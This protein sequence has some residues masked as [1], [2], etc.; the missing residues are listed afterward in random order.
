MR[1]LTRFLACFL[2]A[3]LVVSNVQY[4]GVVKAAE[5]EEVT[6]EAISEES[7]ADVTLE[8]SE[9]AATEKIF[10]FNDL[11]TP[12]GYGYEI[13]V[14]EETGA[15]TIKY[16]ND[17]GYGE[18]RYNLPADFDTSKV[19]KVEVLVEEQVSAIGLK[20]FLLADAGGYV[21]DEWGGAADAMV[22][23]GAP[24]VE[25]EWQFKSLGIF[26]PEVTNEVKLTGIKIT[27]GDATK[28][29]K[30]P[31]AEEPDEFEGVKGTHDESWFAFKTYT[32]EAYAD[33]WSTQT[34][35]VYRNKTITPAADT[36][37][38]LTHVAIMSLYPDDLTETPTY[39]A[40]FTDVTFVSGSEEEVTNVYT[41]ND[42]TIDYD[43]TAIE[44][45]VLANG[46]AN[47]TFTGNYKSVFVAIPEE[48][49]GKE[50]KSITFNTIIA[51]KSD[52]TYGDNIIINPNFAE[53]DLSAWS[54]GVQ[55]ATIKKETAEAP[56]FGDVN[57]YAVIDRDATWVSE[58]GT[59]D[60]RHEFFAQDITAAIEAGGDLNRKPSYKVEF[61][62]KLSDDYKDAP[63]AQRV[64]E[65]A[66][67]IV[68]EQDGAVYLG[69]SYSTQLSG[70][71]S[72]TLTVGEW[73][74]YSGTFDVTHDGTIKQVVIRIIEQGTEYGDLAKGECVKGD[75]YVTGVSLTEVFKP[76][77]TIET[78]IPNWKDAITDAF[79]DDAIAGTCL[80][81]GTI[82]F[83]YLQEL[84]KKHFNA[85]TF[86]NEMK[87]D[88][89]LG[90]TPTLD[91]NG[92]LVYN[93]AVAD[94][95]L[96]QIKG[97]ND[98]DKNDD[99]NFKIRGHVLVWHSQT[100]E[101]FFHEDYD[102]N[103]D[104]VT[105][106]VMNTRLEHY[107]KGVLTHYNEYKFED[108]TSAADMFYGWDIVNEAMSDSTGKPRKASDN[109]NWARVY[110]DE[111]NEY[112]IN[113][114][115]YANKYAPEHIR[116]Y[117][118]DYNDSNEPKASGIAAL[119]AEITSH[120][121]D[122]EN[123]TRIDGVGMQAHHNFGDPTA[124]QIK[125][126]I[127]KYL[128]A[129][130]EGGVVEM[131]EFDVKRSS[132]YDGSAASLASEHAKQAWRFKEIFDVYRATEA[133]KPGSVGGITMWGLVDERSWLQSQGT[134]GGGSTGGAHAPLLFY[135]D[136]YVAKA[137]PAFY[138]F[139]DEYVAEL[140]PFIQSVTVMQQTAEGDFGKGISYDLAGVGT[141]VPMWTADGLTFKVDVVDATDDKEKDTITVYLD[142]AGSKSE[143]DYKKV[144][145]DRTAEGVTSTEAGYSTIINIP[146][147]N[148]VSGKTFSFDIAVADNDKVSVFN[149]KKGSQA[150]T[151]K[152]YAEAIIKPYASIQYGSVVI[153]AEED[154]SWSKVDAIPLTIVLGA[155]AS[156]TVKALWDNEYLYVYGEVKDAELDNTSTQAHEVD[157]L[158]VFIDENNAKA[159]S[160][161]DD[162]KQYRISY[163][164]VQSF[165]GPKCTADNVISAARITEDGYVVEAAFK[166]TDIT[167]AAGQEIGIEFQINDA[168]GGTRT[169]T[170]SWFD[171]SG[172]GWS[173][174]A[175]FGVAALEANFDMS[176]D[177][178]EDQVY[179]GSAIKP[180]IAVYNG[181][182]KLEEG[183]DYTVK[184]SNNVKVGEAIVT[185]TGKGNFTKKETV[186]FNI[187]AK[188]IAAEDVD[189]ADITVVYNKKEQKPVPVINYN[190]KKL[191]NK[192]DFTVEYPTEGE[193]AYKEAGE[194]VIKVT[195][196]GNFTGT[197]EIKLAITNDTLMSKAKIS[198]IAAQAYTGAA[199]T[200]DV[201]VKVGKDTL[202]KDKHYT[203]EYSDNIAVGT[204]T[205]TVKAIAGSG[206]VGEKTATF[207]INGTALKTAKIAGIEKAYDYTGS[208]I[209][210][211]AK[212]TVGDKVLVADTD[213]TVE[214][215]NNIDAGKATVVF[216][217]IGGYTGTVKK[218][219]KIN[220]L[221]IAG[222]EG[223]AVAAD[224]SY[225]FV[226]GGV[227]PVPTVTYNGVALEMGKD[228][229]V[230]YKNN[231]A[232]AAADAKKLPSL[233]VKGKGNFKG[234]ADSVTFLIDAK[235]ISG[236]D[237]ILDDVAYTTKKNGFKSKVTIVDT[238]GK[239]LSAGKD[240]DKNI[241]FTYAADTTV[242]NGKEDVARKAG[243]TI[244][245]KDVLP[246]GTKVIVTVTGK[247]AYLDTV[248]GEYLIVKANVAKAKVK[249]T[250][251]TYVGMPVTLDADDITVKVGK[252]TLV[253]GQDYEIVGYEN[254]NAKGKASVTI[255][256]IGEYGGTKTVKFTIKQKT[257][258]LPE[259]LQKLFDL[260]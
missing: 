61:W 171:A 255:K 13:D 23:Y 190:G 230:S 237:L 157:S 37:S 59:Q 239:K 63:E 89:T 224:A 179:T 53:D 134:V 57:T 103:K 90:S 253:L 216:T 259:F 203:V 189:A 221:N 75:Y 45:E 144:T 68:T 55:K 118:N 66:P 247:G 231:K 180:E 242:K 177:K 4:L 101:W 151:S 207:K 117:Y 94:R 251:Q 137:K 130:G 181:T 64:V 152:Y 187:V 166:W 136:N 85:I 7:S 98:L 199:I 30:Q 22:N 196:K 192:T 141:V 95:M 155:E 173:S 6:S 56:I 195:A 77:T 147:E 148:I 149:D 197:R 44:V 214:Y 48:L 109:S 238:D 29:E 32:A 36:N 245:A 194:Y 145:V 26:S 211:D 46:S 96:A 252:E 156:A 226:K 164:N 217:G 244:D 168:K 83:D 69:A 236:C 58:D 220:A 206:Y 74:K 76:Q 18:I 212:L 135:I 79:G 54:M 11:G 84:A 15:A 184:Y 105:P 116:L 172:N 119:V 67:Y 62:A 50:I 123:P 78:D 215:T 138:A 82:T 60:A 143:G 104:F 250:A 27:Y 222:L 142:E 167:P 31:P 128:A 258:V 260:F 125:S 87:P 160:Y 107:I 153:D 188:D 162:D 233:T 228:F 8:D 106:D 1:K 70:T 150:T 161:Q 16:N 182:A 49:A 146:M 72:Q 34:E 40:T 183:K 218:T 114:F 21:Q 205:V 80:G 178:I 227:K 113:A 24:S 169:G 219:F 39:T 88:I 100:P 256:G 91:E 97:W 248:S 254:N 234:T 229:T 249:V 9:D 201:V 257:V 132:T 208:Q 124:N 223:F 200:P 225:P 115:R 186:K 176:V 33:K 41:F 93:F 47:M 14:D 10:T 139:F 108:G 170:A 20:L 241:A 110:G 185:V 243:D 204:A 52:V 127:D 126:A 28:E 165:N 92:E 25:P 159:D 99:I 213:Y 122:A 12:F 17:G 112:I 191:K 19:S 121:K 38:K 246:T 43:P 5:A 120:E 42:L 2:A 65:F 86:E 51:P 240:Y 73:T 235:A 209:V 129:L 163:E 140:D 210:A 35:V 102:V 71:L 81:S 193:G 154:A 198:K 3:L 232:V 175:V 133:E 202:E 158:E 131:T 174:P 111:S